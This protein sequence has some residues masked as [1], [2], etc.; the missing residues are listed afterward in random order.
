MRDGLSR[1]MKMIILSEEL[2]F[3]LAFLEIPN[4]CFR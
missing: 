1:L 3:R 4:F 2:L